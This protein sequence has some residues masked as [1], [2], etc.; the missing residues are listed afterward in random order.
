MSPEEREQISQ[1]S[2]GDN[3]NNW[4][5]GVVSS[6]CVDCNKQ[7]RN[8]KS[9]RCVRCC[10][11]GKLNPFY[12]KKHLPENMVKM[13]ATR[14][15]KPIRLPPNTKQISINGVIYKSGNKAARALNINRALINYR[16]KSDKYPEYYWV[17]IPPQAWEYGFGGNNF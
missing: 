3:N 4:R 2:I 6:H 13:V 14:R 15:L 1:K 7:I 12:G 10:K 9:K 5:G 17:P 16:I 11:I 8:K